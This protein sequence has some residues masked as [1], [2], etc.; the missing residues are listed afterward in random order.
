MAHSLGILGT[1]AAVPE[2]VL[3][4]EQLAAMV[5]IDPEWIQA[6]TGIHERRIADDRTATSDLATTA[7]HRAIAAAG[8]SAKD[9]G[10]VICATVTPDTMFP[11]TACLVQD[12]IGARNAGAFD[13][14]AGCS[15]F[16]Y[17]LACAVS[18]LQ[19]GVCRYAL[20][21]G[22]DTLSKITDFTDRTTCVLFADGAGAVVLGPTDQGRGFLSF[23]LGAD[24]RG[25]PLIQQAAGGSRLPASYA[26]VKARQHFITM[27]GP[28]V[29]KFAVRILGA[30]AEAALAKAGFTT[31]D[32]DLL[33]PHQANIR[34]IEAAINRM[35]VPAK[36]V[37]VNL[38]RY[39][40]TSSAS[41]PIALDEVVRRGMLRE[42]DVLV[43]V[44]FGAGLTWG[45]TVLRW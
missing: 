27:D 32:I 9:I 10:M 20:V 34:I 21:I 23:E 35:N 29:F 7:A 17:G 22:A 44:A 2:T 12:R 42:R 45:A 26:T 25:S 31:D 16:I 8:I 40:N 33:I 41:L 11:A 38:D 30:S 4:N 3:T 43:M 36:K 14:S 19:T 13:L 39:G 5:D 15:G 24:G 6:R 28:E 1:G 18:L 37:Y